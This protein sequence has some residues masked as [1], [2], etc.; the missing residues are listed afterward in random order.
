MS[1][2]KIELIMDIECY[3]EYLLIK[4]MRRDKP[5]IIQGFEM[6]EGQRLDIA[7]I[8][9]ILAKRRIITFNGTGYDIPI[10]TYALSGASC[11]ELKAATNQ[12]IQFKL[13]PWAFY[14]RYNLR[15]IRTLD[16]IDLIEPAPGVAISLKMYGARLHSQ[17]L[18]DL[19]IEHESSISPEQRIVLSDYC[20]N[21]LRTTANLADAIQPRIDLRSALGLKYAMDF[22]SKSDAQIGEAVLRK[23]CEDESGKQLERPD[24]DDRNFSYTP[25]KFIKFH[26]PEMQEVFDRMCEADYR[27]V[28]GEVKMPPSLEGYVIKVNGKSYALGIGGIHSKESRIHNVAEKG[29]EIWDYDVA[30]YYPNIILLCGL[31]PLH[32][33]KHFLKAYRDLVTMRLA[34]KRSGDKVMNEGLKISINGSYGKFGSKYSVLFSPELMVQTTVTGQL[35]LLM[36]VE[37]IEGAGIEV[38]SANTDGIVSRPHSSDVP[39]LHAIIRQ[40]CGETGFEMEGTRYSQVLSRDVNTYVA[41]KTGD[42]TATFI[43][44]LGEQDTRVMFSEKSVGAIKTKGAFETMSI[45]KTPTCQISVDAAIKYLTHRTPIMNTIRACTDIRRFLSARNVTGGALWNGSYLGKCVRWVYVKNGA[46]ILTK[47]KG[48]QVA[49]S[50]GCMPVM[51]LPANNSMQGIDIDYRKY[52]DLAINLLINS[53]FRFTDDEL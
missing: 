52:A 35:G 51:D 50:A 18:Q 16:H 13:K 25:P 36:L 38:I 6:F 41:I 45:S 49:T 44:D 40:W 19:P 29:Y 15:E 39:T 42:E 20:S 53:G 24:T 37:R 10:L 22:R 3:S 48:D 17:R 12:I 11:K 32:I 47:K 4:F 26:T 31:Y 43:N 1:S 23:M 21:D 46:P 30:S 33:G 9:E 34:A 7:R 8:R 2:D 28:N 14:K 5:E 27:L